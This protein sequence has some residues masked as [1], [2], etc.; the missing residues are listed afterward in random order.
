MTDA[1]AD[2]R[3]LADK[4]KRDVVDHFEQENGW[5][6]VPCITTKAVAQNKPAQVANRDAYLELMPK[7]WDF[8]RQGTAIDLSLPSDRCLEGIID[9]MLG[10]MVF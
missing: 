8:A 4:A 10:D 1:D 5:W 7:A 3:G 6:R 9:S 2:E